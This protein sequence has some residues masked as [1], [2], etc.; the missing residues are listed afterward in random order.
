MAQIELHLTQAEHGP[1][2]FV[3]GLKHAIANYAAYRRTLHALR[4]ASRETLWDLDIDPG[5]LKQTAKRAVAA[6]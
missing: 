1:T 3:H 6:N 2:G 5:A 4:S